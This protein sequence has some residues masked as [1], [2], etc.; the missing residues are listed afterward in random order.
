MNKS[1][2]SR[3][4]MNSG[5]TFCKMFPWPVRTEEHHA[6]FHWVVNQQD[7]K[8]WLIFLRGHE[9]SDMNVNNE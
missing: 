8:L 4:Q 6:S 2:G 7:L 1:V 9:V 3:L 5:F